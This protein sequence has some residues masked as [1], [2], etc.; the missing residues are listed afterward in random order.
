MRALIADEIDLMS[1]SAAS[2]PRRYRLA[3]LRERRRSRGVK[4]RALIVDEGRTWS[5]LSAV[6]SLAA[7]GWSVAIGSPGA[8]G[9]SASSRCVSSRHDVPSLGVGLD[10]FSNAVRQAVEDSG[11]EV[12]FGGGDAEVYALCMERE[13]IPA[14]VPYP[15]MPI[16]RRAFDKLELCTLAVG[17]GLAAPWTAAADDDADVDGTMMVKSRWHWDPH[18]G[19]EATR[20]EATIETGRVAINGRVRELR[21]LGAE[22]VLQEPVYGDQLSLIVLRSRDGRTLGTVFQQMDHC[23]PTPNGWTVRRAHDS[24]RRRAGARGGQAPRRSRLERPGR[25][26]SSSVP[27]TASRASST[28]TGGS[29]DRWPSPWAPAS[30][31][32]RFGRRMRRVRRWSPRPRARAGEIPAA[33]RRSPTRGVRAPWRAVARRGRHPRVRARRVPQHSARERPAPGLHVSSR[34]RART[35]ANEIVPPTERPGTRVR[36]AHRASMSAGESRA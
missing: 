7:A 2:D 8:R 27:T 5:T 30:T 18:T 23:W 25:A 12:V 33:W 32:P 28:S 26:S 31:S 4:P 34:D 22:P 36:A 17:Y 16:V 1:P 10:A 6:R 21:R 19:H 3:M 15:P 24:A 9:L 29:M 11:A 35:G 20:V 13:K 14:I